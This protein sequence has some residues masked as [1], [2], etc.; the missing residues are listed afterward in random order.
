MISY[1]RTVELCPTRSQR[2]VKLVILISKL[3]KAAHVTHRDHV[4][5]Q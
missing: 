4:R 5:V 3:E 2:E 1:G